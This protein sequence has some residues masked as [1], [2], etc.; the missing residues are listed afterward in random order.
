MSLNEL[1]GLGR[2]SD[3]APIQTTTDDTLPELIP[4]DSLPAGSRL[5]QKREA[6]MFARGESSAADRTLEI[7]QRNL[8]ETAEFLRRATIENCVPY[9]FAEATAKQALLERAIIDAKDKANFADQDYRALELGFVN[10]YHAYK[11]AV[12]AVRE[13][14]D[15]SGRPV[16]EER[17][18]NALWDINRY[19]GNEVKKS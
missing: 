18:K 2:W 7:Y 13:R 9:L 5:Y 3:A 15:A 8:S 17:R 12:R 11:A 1:L 10:D 6:M 19:V 16:N 4:E 14:I